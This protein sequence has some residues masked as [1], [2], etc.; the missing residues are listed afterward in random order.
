ME[1]LFSIHH[2]GAR[3]GTIGFPKVMPLHGSIQCTA[4]EADK[5][6]CPQIKA[7]LLNDGY[8]K[9]EVIQNCIGK[10]RKVKFNLNYDPN[11]SSIFEKNNFFDN[12]YSEYPDFDYLMEE[13]HKKVKE[14]T[15]DLVELDSIK[16]KN[17]IDF[18]CIDTQGAELE[19]LE[20]GINSIQKTVG[21]YTEVNFN[22]FYKDIPLFG[23]VYNFLDKLGFQLINIDIHNSWAP[24]ALPVGFRLNKVISQ[25]DALFL[26]K[27]NHFQNINEQRKL[28]FAALVF[29]QIEYAAYCSKDLNILNNWPKNYWQNAVDIFLSIARKDDSFMP[30][31]FN[32]IY[33]KEKSFSRFNDNKTINQ[34]KII[35]LIKKIVFLRNI[36]KHLKSFILDFKK[37]Y[38][39]LYKKFLYYFL[40]Y[41]SIEMFYKEIGQIHFSNRL[42]NKRIKRMVKDYSKK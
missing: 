28:V 7:K 20:S 10:S 31:T 35:I 30:K 17:N 12:Y 23:E 41:N 8:K 38:K 16:H 22:P 11:T 6:C 13:T 2:I 24:R 39:S 29:G 26:R 5:E 15:L 19:I 33:S 40:T 14:L 25:G 4:Y 42:K 36:I 1:E 32:E 9:V 34:K 27:P 21:I 37:F 18:L 3:S